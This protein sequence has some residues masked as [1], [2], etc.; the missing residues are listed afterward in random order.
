M[1]TQSTPAKVNLRD[2]LA[3]FDDRWS[4]KIVANMND[5]HVKLVKVEGEFLW[6]THDETDELFLVLNGRLTIKLREGDVT[7]D[8]GELFV[9]PRGVEHM[10]VAAAECHILLLEP[11]GTVN[12]G[13]AGGERTAQDERI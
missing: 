4:P 13:D 12:T 10:P 6:H 9:V 2:K 7:L 5:Y 1:T 3:R 8:E 11:A